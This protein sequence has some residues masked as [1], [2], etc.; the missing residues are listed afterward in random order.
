MTAGETRVYL[1][2]GDRRSEA[3]QIVSNAGHNAVRGGFDLL[4]NGNV[5]LTTFAVDNP[6]EPLAKMLKEAGWQEVTVAQWGG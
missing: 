1:K 4:H 2:H 3:Q 6:S 5:D